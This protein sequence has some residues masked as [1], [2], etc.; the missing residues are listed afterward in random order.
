M[1]RELYCLKFLVIL[2]KFLSK[3]LFQANCFDLSSGTNIFFRLY[4]FY[5]WW[6]ISNRKH[7]PSSQLVNLDKNEEKQHISSTKKLSRIFKISSEELE[8][9]R[10]I[11]SPRSIISKVDFYPCLGV[12]IIMTVREWA[13]F[14]YLVFL[15]TSLL[16]VKFELFQISVFCRLKK[17]QNGTSQSWKK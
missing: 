8:H 5:S 3:N 12:K 17:V 4:S 9:R 13:W 10:E 6:K 11:K 7:T 15:K 1:W 2:A 16:C 14:S